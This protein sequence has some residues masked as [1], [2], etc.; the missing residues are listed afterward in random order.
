MH[1]NIQ[2]PEF[3]QCPICFMDL[4]PVSGDNSNS[5]GAIYSM[6]N[7]ARKIAEIQTTPVKKEKAQSEVYLTGKL[8]LNE[9]KTKNVSSW[10]SGRVERLFVDF[11]GMS[12][13]KNDHLLEIYS[14]E[15]ISA[16]EEYLQAFRTNSEFGLKAA[17][18]KLYLLGIQNSQ[19]KELESQNKT[20]AKL[21]IHSPISGVV[22][23]K[24]VSEGEYVNKGS[25][26]FSVA[27]LSHL[28]MYLDVFE[29]DLQFVYLGQYVEFATTSHSGKTFNGVVAFIDPILHPQTRTVKIR[30]NVNNVENLLKPDMFVRAIL[31]ANINAE[32]NIIHNELAGKWICP[33]HL[34]DVHDSEGICSICEMDLVKAESIPNI[35]SSNENSNPLVIPETSVLKTGKRAI[36]Y[37]QTQNKEEILFEGREVKLGVKVG[38]NYIVIDGLEEGELV[39]SNGAFKIDSALQISAKP[40]MMNPQEKEIVEDIDVQVPAQFLQSVLPHYLDL[41]TALAND[42]LKSSKMAM[43]QIHNITMGKESTDAI[44]MPSM[45]PNKTIEAIRKSFEEISIIMNASAKQGLLKGEFNEAFC[46]MAFDWKGASWLQKGTKINNPYF[47]SQ[48]LRCGEI[49]QTYEA[50]H[51]K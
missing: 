50:S 21:T 37:V 18:E 16:Q 4:I 28:W 19:I 43:M 51:G 36:V 49:K 30:V 35:V 47:G 3:G 14:P 48:M 9:T 45:K 24:N 11:T 13:R 22:I 44:M 46:P 32:G 15:L 8:S 42:D 20:S 31:K 2:L 6:S 23:K 5:D 10:V 25:K 26:L 38:D 17:R 40:S 1:P 29:N 39:V 34:D 27:D 12:V 41:Q 33:M 7:T